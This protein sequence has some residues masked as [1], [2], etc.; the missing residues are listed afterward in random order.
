MHVECKV[1]WVR[2]L[3]QL[4]F[5]RKSDCLECAVLPCLVVC[6]TLLA[7]SFFLSFS[8]KHVHCAYPRTPSALSEASLLL[9]ILQ[10]SPSRLLGRLVFEVGVAPQRLEEL[11]HSFQHMHM[12]EVLVKCCCPQLPAKTH[13]ATHRGV[14]STQQLCICRG[15]RRPSIQFLHPLPLPPL[16]P[17]PLPPSPALPPP[18]AVVALNDGESA[19]SLGDLCVFSEKQLTKLL[20]LLRGLCMHSRPRTYMYMSVYICN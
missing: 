15:S 16:P 3:R 6:M 9:S 18:A 14:P 17:S 5:L 10:E 7:S 2:V 1:L 20:T 4:I 12:M 8:L 11:M 13:A 19:G